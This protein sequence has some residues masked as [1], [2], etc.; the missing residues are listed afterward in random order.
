LPETGPMAAPDRDHR[1]DGVVAFSFEAELHPHKFYLN[2]C[3]LLRIPYGS[4]NSKC[5]LEYLPQAAT[6]EEDS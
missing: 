5:V 3:D 2:L 1:P 4:K 6:Y